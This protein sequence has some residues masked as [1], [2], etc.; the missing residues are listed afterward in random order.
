[1]RI[2]NLAP[3]RIFLYVVLFA[4]SA[5]LLGLSAARIKYTLNL[6]GGDVLTLP[7]IGPYYEPILA[8]AIATTGA[9]ILWCIFTLFGSAT[10]PLVRLLRTELFVLLVLWLLWI[11]GAAVISAIYLP[12]G[13]C[14]EFEECRLIA[15]LIG[16]A[17]MGWLTISGLVIIVFA[18]CYVNGGVGLARQTVP[19]SDW[20]GRSR[21]PEMRAARNE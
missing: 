10:K 8:E 1:M 7:G 19:G 14:Q 16:F 21:L 18:M 15:A 2:P 9:T 17:W 4:F 20:E 3:V 11:A 6:H 13:W 5:V 12:I